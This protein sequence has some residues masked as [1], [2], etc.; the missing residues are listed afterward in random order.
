MFGKDSFGNRSS[1]RPV[2]GYTLVEVAL[3]MSIVALVFS[4]TIVSYIHATT[5]AKWSGYSLAAQALA[6]QQIEQARSALWDPTMGAT[7]YDELLNLPTV[8]TNT[9]N[10]PI[11]GTNVLFATNY[12]T[13]SLFTNNGSQFH[14]VRVDTVWN[15]VGYATN[16]QHVFTNTAVSYFAPDNPDPND[17]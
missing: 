11:S 12:I 7:G 15:F 1:K 10:L 16:R 4:V 14:M 3:A 8:T 13:V 9:L 17:F 6:V 5:R 2:S